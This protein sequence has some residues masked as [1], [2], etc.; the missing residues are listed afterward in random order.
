MKKIIIF[1]N[2]LLFSILLIP[3][4]VFAFTRLDSST[5]SPVTDTTVYIGVNMTYGTNKK[6]QETHHV[7]TYDPEYLSYE[8]IQ[9][10]CSAKDIGIINVEPGRITVDKTKAN[11]NPW[12]TGEVYYLTFRVLKA[13]QNKVI[14]QENG[15]GYFDDGNLIPHEDGSSI[16]IIGKDPSSNVSLR[17][18]TVVGYQLYPVFCAVCDN[19]D[20]SLKVPSDVK[21]ITI[22]VEKGDEKQV[23]TGDGTQPLQYGPNKLKVT[24]K[25]QNGNTATYNL[26]VEREDITTTDTSLA[27]LTVSNTDIAYEDGVTEY[28]ATV[29]KSIDSVLIAARTNDKNATILG[30]GTKQLQIGDNEFILSLTSSKGTKQDYKINIRRSTEEIQTVNKSTKLV[31]LKVNGLVLDL[32]NNKKTFI[33]GIPSTSTELN[34]SAVTESKN[35]TYEIKNNE[36]LTTGINLIEVVVKEKD[37]STETYTIIGYKKPNGQEVSD[38]SK[39]TFTSDTIFETTKTDTII[40]KEMID[41][42]NENKITLYYNIINMYGGLQAQAVLKNNLIDGLEEILIKINDSPIT[43]Q[44]SIPEGNEL[45]IYLDDVYKDGNTIKIYSYN[46]SGNYKLI[47]DGIKVEK[48]YVKFVSNGDKYYIFTTNTLIQETD[49]LTGFIN[50]YSTYLMISGVVLLLI[51][52]VPSILGKNKKQ[53]GNNEPSY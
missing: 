2:I 20:Y 4:K 51:I 43:Y 24:V 36:N 10:S 8:G 42:I 14:I 12:N 19:K 25:A 49:S 46:D 18:F 13:G 16:T 32:S 38:L 35:A 33:F 29:S 7:L 27:E 26:L 9:W 47:T 3:S 1:L 21:S 17:S 28:S 11:G 15:S 52:I 39:A 41:K 53:K 44:S 5:Q 48:G 50:K 45:L 37:D 30:T 22:V 40:T 6:I 23:V 34:I 31:S